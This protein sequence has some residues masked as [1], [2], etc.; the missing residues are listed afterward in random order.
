MAYALTVGYLPNFSSPVAFTCMIRQNFP[1][2][3]FPVYNMLKVVSACKPCLAIKKLPP[4]S[5]VTI[6]D[7]EF[8]EGGKQQHFDQLCKTN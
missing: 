6:R 1:C 4:N 3:I 5:R 2:Q 7:N 8:N